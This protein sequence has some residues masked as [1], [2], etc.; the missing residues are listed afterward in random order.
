MKILRNLIVA[1][2]LILIL[3]SFREA[4]RTFKNLNIS[5]INVLAGGDIGTPFRQARTSRAGEQILPPFVQSGI[6]LLRAN[7][8]TAYRFSPAF[9]QKRQRLL[10]GAYPIRY[11]EHAHYLLLLDQEAPDR[12]CSQVSREEGVVL[13]YCP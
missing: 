9:E 4:P 5:W 7:R 13:V 6:S 2:I 1:C 3:A 8:V 11:E 10:E 12:N